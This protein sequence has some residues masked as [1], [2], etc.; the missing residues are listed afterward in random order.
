MHSAMDSLILQVGLAG[1]LVLCLIIYTAAQRQAREINRTL[2]V[3]LTMILFWMVGMVVGSRETAYPIWAT[4]LLVP[5]SCF[6]APLFLLL[7]LRYA[8]VEVFERRSAARTALLAPFW[9]FMLAFF[10]NDWHGLMVDARGLLSNEVALSSAGALFWAFQL[11]SNGVAA[12][13]LVLCMKIAW[14]SDSASERRS[15]WLLCAAALA[16]LAAHLSHLLQWVPSRYPM[17][18]GS[19]GITSLLIVAAIRKYRLLDVQPIARRDVVEA[20]SDGVIIADVDEIVVDLNPAAAKLLGTERDTACGRPLEELLGELGAPDRSK[21]L[22]EMLCTLRSGETPAR[23]EIETRDGHILEISAGLPSDSQGQLAGYFLVLRDRSNER[24][25]ERLLHQSQKLESV[26]VLAAGIAHEVNNPLSFVR[27]NFAHLK[28]LSD[29]VRD[30]L[31]ALPAKVVEELRDMPEV[32]DESVSGL[33]R[34]QLI[35][36]GLLRFS[37]MPSG[38][39]VE[40]NVNDVIREAARF[41]TLDRSATAQLEMDLVADLPAVEASP[42]QLTQVLLN[43]FLNAKHALKGSSSPRIVASTRRSDDGVEI[44]VTDNGP[45]IPIEIREKVFDP[46]FTTG[47]PGDGTG[48]GLTITFDIVREHG[49]TLE[50][51]APANGGACFV[52]RLPAIADA[53]FEGA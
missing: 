15:M 2:S 43:L 38:H 42:E 10:T 16:P 23:G 52:I 51:E 24:R 31:G 22:S 37:R 46:F 47:A 39:R 8:R 33:D 21:F 13:A 40:C 36:Q 3:L 35:V 45:G 7:M 19:L 27:S 6:M 44:R 18:P 25:A 49:G 53:V 4:L 32:I 29:L 26:G 34:I 20:S 48:L 11:W 5:P 12:A 30:E 41:A 14:R 50:L 1:P 17:T 28:H 9:F